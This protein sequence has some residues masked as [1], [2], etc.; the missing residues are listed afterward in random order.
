MQ[1]GEYDRNDSVTVSA[2]RAR[3]AAA[4]GQGQGSSRMG[5]TSSWTGGW[6]ATVSCRP[7]AAD[8]VWRMP[9]GEDDH[10]TLLVLEQTARQH[11]GC[12]ITPGISA[13]TDRR[14]EAQ[15]D[16]EEEAR[17]G[18]RR[19]SDQ[20]YGQARTPAKVHRAVAAR[21]SPVAPF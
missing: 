11:V 16:E 12:R 4:R 6:Q 7:A 13:H 8:I 14:I 21:S 15:R 19:L 1:R 20:D 18:H 5:R 9:D 17:V 2:I 10:D 3:Q